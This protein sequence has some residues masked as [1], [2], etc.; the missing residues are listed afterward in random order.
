MEKQK[1]GKLTDGVHFDVENRGG[2]MLAQLAYVRQ[3]NFRRTSS[4]VRYGP[5]PPF[6]RARD[7]DCDLADLA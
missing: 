4:N 7:G 2:L 3:K 5:P 1:D 6:L